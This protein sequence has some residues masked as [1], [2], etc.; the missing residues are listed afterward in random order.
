MVHYIRLEYCSVSVISLI[1]RSE[2][3]NVETRT[4][5]GSDVNSIVVKPSYNAVI[6]LILPEVTAIGVRLSHA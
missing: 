3:T 5:L 6:R 4:E 2:R 1:A